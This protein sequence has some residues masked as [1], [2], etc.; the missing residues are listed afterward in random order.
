MAA[1]DLREEHLARNEAILRAK[2]AV[3]LDKGTRFLEQR[4]QCMFPG[5]LGAFLN[6][7]LGM[8]YRTVGREE[9]L[10]RAHTQVDIVLDAARAHGQAPATIFDGHL[11]RYLEHDEAFA[12][13]NRRHAR[14]QELEGLLREIYVARVEPVSLLLHQ[15]MGDSYSDLVRSVFPNRDA[16]RRVVE[17]EFLYTDA[18]FALAREERDLLHAPPLVRR[19]VFEVLKDTYGWY[20]GRVQGSL[21]EVYAPSPA[22]A[23]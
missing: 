2:V 5:T 7:L 23:S 4:V 9:I 18:L 1:A 20:K 13:A 17:R 14:Y 3:E 10:R 19:E 21:D 6:P 8:A 15:G 22:P 12:R 16:A 11:T